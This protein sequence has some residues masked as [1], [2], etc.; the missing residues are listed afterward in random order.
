VYTYYPRLYNR[1]D[2]LRGNI[3]KLSFEYFAK[4]KKKMLANVD[5]VTLLEEHSKQFLKSRAMFPHELRTST[6]PSP[7][8]EQNDFYNDAVL[9]SLSFFFVL[10]FSY[11]I[12]QL[13]K[14]IVWEKESKIKEGMKMMGLVRFLFFFY[15]LNLQHTHTHTYIHTFL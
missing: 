6:F 4:Q 15:P 14:S 5:N 9:N 1:N 10:S 7:K 3:S 11:S 12:F 13:I 2:V 8:Y